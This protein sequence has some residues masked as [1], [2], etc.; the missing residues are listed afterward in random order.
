[1]LD[2]LGFLYGAER[3]GSVWER[4]EALLQGFHERNPHLA[5][6]SAAGQLTQGN[7]ILITYGDQFREPGF[8]PLQTLH[9]VLV[10]TLDHPTSGVHILPFFPYSSDDGFSVIDYTEVN[11]DFGTWADVERLGGDLRLMFD[12]VINHVSRHSEW[13][14]RFLA[15]DPEYTDWFISFDPDAPTDW[16]AQ[17]TR[18]RALPLL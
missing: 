14:Q 12:A 13:F 6:P 8:P 5:A 16:V 1:M 11:P 3:A 10:E 18:P 15:G 7:A 2:H 9:E 4:L 17:V